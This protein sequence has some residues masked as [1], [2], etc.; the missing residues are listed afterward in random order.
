MEAARIKME[1]ARLEKQLE[2]LSGSSSSNSNPVAKP[3]R[4]HTLSAA[5]RAKMKKSQQE[6]RAREKKEIPLAPKPVEKPVKKKR[7]LSV[8]QKAAI[9][10]AK[11]EYWAKRKAAEKAGK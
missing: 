5:A 9:S 7:Q 1:I 10:R 8:A 4:K 2:N 6:R 11:K 3:A